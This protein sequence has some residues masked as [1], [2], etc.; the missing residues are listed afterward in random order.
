MRRI[1]FLILL[2]TALAACKPAAEQS[3]STRRV[4]ERSVDASGSSSGVAGSSASAGDG[5]RVA[6]VIGNNAY[7]HAAR[8]ATAKPD[9]EAVARLL[10]ELGFRVFLHTDVDQEGLVDAVDEFKAAAGRATAAFVYFAG[11]GIESPGQGGN[12][13]IPVDAKLEKESHLKSQA[14]ALDTLL[15]DLRPLQASTRMVV[16]DCCRNNPLEGRTWVRSGGGGLGA[17]KTADLDQTTLVVFSAGPGK[18]AKDRL[19][20]DDKHSPFA[21]ALMQELA[22]PGKSCLEVFGAVE[23]AVF[24][25][26][27][28]VQRP[29]TFLNGNLSP[30]T[31]FVFRPGSAAAAAPSASDHNMQKELAMKAEMEKLKANAE[32]PA[33]LLPPAE[34]ESAKA[35]LAAMKEQVERLTKELAAKAQAPAQ[36]AEPPSSTDGEAVREHT[37][38]QTGGFA[39]VGVSVGLSL[40]GG[41]GG[42]K[43]S[44]AWRFTTND[45]ETG[46]FTLS[47]A[48]RAEMWAGNVLIRQGS[49]DV[50]GEQVKIVIGEATFSGRVAN[51]HIQGTGSGAK[52]QR[53]WTW[54]AEPVVIESPMK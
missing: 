19:A 4:L 32:A 11:H 49:C 47:A 12:Y 17:V 39:A 23:T 31:A 28:E 44:G 25:R 33:T 43:F 35:E 21:M 9:A 52:G 41:A 36:P 27:G 42:D 46:V 5:S 53:G 48:G 38:G 29:K 1:A 8:L 24:S 30:F 54:T 15:A 50:S 20:E 14:Y 2:L 51:G 3:S 22:R 10:P 40:P 16:L 45:G 37:A 18:P 6:L 13:L 7:Q 26:T 34:D